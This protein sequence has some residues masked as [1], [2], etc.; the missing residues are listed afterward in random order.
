MNKFN[1]ELLPILEELV[2]D[3]GGEIDAFK[4]VKYARRIWNLKL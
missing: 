2:I 4:I 3:S 1:K